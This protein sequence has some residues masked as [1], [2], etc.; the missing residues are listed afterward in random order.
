M[1]IT[2]MRQMRWSWAAYSYNRSDH[3][4]QQPTSLVGGDAR[5]LEGVRDED[6]ACGAER[7]TFNCLGSSF[8][9]MV[10]PTIVTFSQSFSGGKEGGNKW[11]KQ[12]PNEIPCQSQGEKILGVSPKT[13]KWCEIA[14]NFRKILFGNIFVTFAVVR[15][16]VLLGVSGGSGIAIGGKQQL[17]LRGWDHYWGSRLSSGYGWIGEL[18]S[19][20]YEA[21]E[22]PNPWRKTIKTLRS[23]FRHANPIHRL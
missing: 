20:R 15:G 21:S 13:S 8:R 4:S 22:I 11:V 9:P 2:I 10:W 3:Q 6:T 7:A 23:L 19:R 18:G 17:M 14:G 5:H 1:K 12:C 16:E